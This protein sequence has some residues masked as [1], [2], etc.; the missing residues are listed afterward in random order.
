MFSVGL[1][2]MWM[3]FNPFFLFIYLVFLYNPKKIRIP[4]YVLAVIGLACFYLLG[5]L[6]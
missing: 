2:F 1:S 6:V 3:L 4:R 5:K